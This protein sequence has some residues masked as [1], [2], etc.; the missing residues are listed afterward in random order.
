MRFDKTIRIISKEEIQDGMGGYE[1]VEEIT[2]T[3]NAF[4]TPVN[5]EIARKEYGI[6]T[7]KTLK[8]FTKDSV[9]ED[10][11]SIE[12]DGATYSVVA[13]RDF[14]RMKMLVVARES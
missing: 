6:V 3:F 7:K 10:V 5:A 8:L 13:F 11:G 4:S 2:S 9:S 12:Y 14:G 1:I